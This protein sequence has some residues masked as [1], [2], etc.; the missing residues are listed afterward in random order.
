MKEPI[1]H[2]PDK[3]VSQHHAGMDFNK[4]YE[5][6]LLDDSAYYPEAHMRGNDYTELQNTIKKRDRAKLIKGQFSKIA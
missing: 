4:G 2:N 1:K 5:T 3:G 6:S